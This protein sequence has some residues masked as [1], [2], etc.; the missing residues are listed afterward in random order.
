MPELVRVTSGLEQERS[1]ILHHTPK[2]APDLAHQRG[3]ESK[4]PLAR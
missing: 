4:S 1:G 3:V 2:H